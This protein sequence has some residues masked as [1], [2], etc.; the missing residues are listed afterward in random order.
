MTCSFSLWRLLASTGKVTVE[1]CW[2]SVYL[3]DSILLMFKCS[4]SI[5]AQ[6]E[7]LRQMLPSGTCRQLPFHD[8]DLPVTIPSGVPEWVQRC[9]F[10]RYLLFQ[11]Q[12]WH[13]PYHS[14]R[15]PRSLILIYQSIVNSIQYDAPS[16]EPNHDDWY[17]RRV[18][19]SNVS[20]RNLK[21]WRLKFIT[22]T[23]RI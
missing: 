2:W 16:M 14:V 7:V 13:S 11:V 23:M 12:I 4:N 9:R 6:S 20:D 10:H 17:N 18:Q 3:I 15:L 8:G 22:T 5:I 1:G 19:P 21:R